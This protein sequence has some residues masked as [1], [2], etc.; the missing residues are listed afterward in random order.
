MSADPSDSDDSLSTLLN[1]STTTLSASD[2]KKRKRK[3][4]NK[5]TTTINTMSI[6]DFESIS[7]ELTKNIQEQ[8]HIDPNT[9]DMSDP[10]DFESYKFL[11]MLV[12]LGLISA[13]NDSSLNDEKNFYA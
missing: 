10:N 11:H 2:K 6:K 8:Y 9:L 5:K 4:N 12:I 7:P 1:E 13:K 3:K